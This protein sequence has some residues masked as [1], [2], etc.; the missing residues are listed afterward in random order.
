MNLLSEPSPP[1][2]VE[3]APRRVAYFVRYAAVLIKNV[4]GYALMLAA[5]GLGSVF[6]IPIGTPLFLIGFAMITLPG[7]RRLTSGALRGITIK[8]HRRKALWWRLA[9][10]LLLPPAA[11]WFLEFQR[12][13]VLHPTQM[14]FSR[15]CSVYGIAIVAAWILTW[16]MLQAINAVVRI[17]PHIRRHV[18]PWLRAHGVHLLPPRSKPRLQNA[19]RSRPNDDQIVTFDRM[20]VPHMH[21]PHVHVPHVHVPH[22]KREK[23]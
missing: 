7:K 18:R 21:V 16:I 8:Y 6:P 14:S 9:I 17:L 12:W 4:V 19:T 5:L 15:L 22:W 20:H 23:K 2:P 3:P 11:L 10:S 13:P 1:G